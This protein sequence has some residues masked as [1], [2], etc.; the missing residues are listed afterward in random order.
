MRSAEQRRQTNRADAAY[1]HETIP[2][3]EDDDIEPAEF[4]SNSIPGVDE[5][6]VNFGEGY[7][8]ER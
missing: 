5:T 1:Q 8:D 2:A 7:P 4:L 6:V 3:K